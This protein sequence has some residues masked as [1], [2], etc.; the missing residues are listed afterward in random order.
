MIRETRNWGDSG[1]LV[2]QLQ[3]MEDKK[4]KQSYESTV[5]IRC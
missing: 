1:E 5:V 3:E 4:S 2:R